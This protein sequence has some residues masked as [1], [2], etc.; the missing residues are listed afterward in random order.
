M[1]YYRTVTITNTATMLADTFSKIP[2]TAYALVFVLIV[3]LSIS[4]AQK[5]FTI[6][7]SVRSG[8]GH[9]VPQ[10]SA[11]MIS[12]TGKVVARPDIAQVTLGVQSHAATA[13]EVMRVNTD[14]YN[15]VVAAVKGSGVEDKDIKTVAYN[16]SPRYRYEQNTGKSI[17]DGYDLYQSLSVKIRKLDSVGQ[18]LSVVTG[19]GANQVG[20]I[21]FTIDDQ[22]ALKAEARKEAIADARV[23]AEAVAESAGLDLGKII[24]F[25]ESSDMS[26]PQPLMYARA[27]AVGGM[28]KSLPA[29]DVQA[30]SQEVQ[31]TVNLT[32]A[33]E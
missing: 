10:G 1:L 24:S 20:D 9:Q 22:D 7:E 21:S 26:V 27:D 15:K 28:E 2:R 32:Y 16:L 17:L 3:W 18:V 33:L 30:G 8:L 19:A 25:S 23:K 11:I 31:V 12:G 14:A 29:P 4:S 5:V 13:A 6:V